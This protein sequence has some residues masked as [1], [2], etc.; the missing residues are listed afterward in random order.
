MTPSSLL[1]DRHRSLDG[2]IFKASVVRMYHCNGDQKRSRVRV[3]DDL[4]LNGMSMLDTLYPDNDM[5]N[6]KA[7]H[8]WAIGTLLIV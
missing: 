6:S 4:L 8:P 1:L 5:R 7:A 2:R 3:G